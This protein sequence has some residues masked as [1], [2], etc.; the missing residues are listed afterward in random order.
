VIGNW[1]DP[2]PDELFYSICARYSQR[3][4]YSS[5][6]FVVAELFGTGQ[7][8]ACVSLPS[9]LSY[10]VS[11]LPPKFNYDIDRIINQHTLLPYFAPFLP[12]ERYTRLRQDMCGNNGPMLHMRAGLMASRVPLPQ[13]LRFCPQCVEEDRRKYGECYWHR[14]HQTPGVEICPLHKSRLRN[15]SAHARNMQT[16]YEF[17]PAESVVPEALPKQL[18]E[19][20]YL[21]EI[22]FALAS[23]T[24]WLLKQ[25]DLSQ[26]LVALQQRYRLRL[27]DIGL[28]TYRGRIDRNELLARFRNVYTLDLL[29][30]LHCDL[31]EHTEDNWLVRLA[32]K[33]DNTQHPLHH[34]LLIHFLGQTAESFFRL[35]TQNKHFGDGPWPC[36]NPVCQHYRQPQVSEYTVTYSPFVSGKP[37]GAFSCTCGFTY[38]R[39]GPDTSAEDRFKISSVRA[40]G[41]LWE[42]RLS[43]LW[44]DETVSLRQI[45][46]QLGVDPLTIKRHASRLDLPFPRPVSRTCR[47]NEAQKLRSP[48]RRM[49][50]QSM[51]EEYRARWLSALQE[52]QDAG[53]KFIRGKC[54]KLYKWLYRHDTAWL[55][56]HLPARR[57][58]QTQVSPVDWQQRDQQLAQLVETSAQ[59]LR[60]QAGNPRQI[61]LAAIGR[62]IGQQALLQQ[63][64]HRLPMTARLVEDFVETRAA[65]ALRRVQWAVK[66]FEEEQYAP[67]RW[68]LIKKAG[69]ERVM[70]MPQI[71]E[72]VENALQQLHDKRERI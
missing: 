49:P 11:Q 61:T 14:I 44:K 72:A 32:H 54:A 7:A 60:H 64:L 10:L 4:R 12:P 16:R 59:Q 26:E 22:F 17:I 25:R 1:P 65:Y 8:M 41:H 69:I 6:R 24:Q 62:D 27:A 43:H 40:F 35:P 45:A 67:K 15:S 28:S 38:L 50:E 18:V 20:E 9:H 31:D 70:A 71:R 30:L 48:L 58:V 55:K 46:R 23:D 66:Q 56:A 21:A 68:E 34:L 42:S 29:R 3:V 33:P 13:W 47:L 39:T 51:L 53:M 63:H 2:Y 19:N 52:Y 57:S 36:L 5:K 37:I